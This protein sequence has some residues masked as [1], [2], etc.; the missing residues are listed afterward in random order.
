M[1]ETVEMTLSG[2]TKPTIW[3]DSFLEEIVIDVQRE[4]EDGAVLEVSLL[5]RP[6]G[7]ETTRRC[8]LRVRGH[9]D[10]FTREG[11]VADL[12]S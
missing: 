4:G 9:F 10:Q 1:D 8:L 11:W 5:Q 7:Q 3:G 12:A 2:G 6:P